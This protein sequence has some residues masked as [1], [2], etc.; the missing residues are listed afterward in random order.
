MLWYM[1]DVMHLGTVSCKSCSGAADEMLMEM[2]TV[3]H[4]GSDDRK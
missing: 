4:D 3:I 2:M 1:V